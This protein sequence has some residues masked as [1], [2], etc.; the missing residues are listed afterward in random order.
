MKKGL[1]I[2]VGIFAFQACLYMFLTYR[3]STGASATKSTE[4]LLSVAYD[5]V[6]KVLV[7]GFDKTSVELVKK[8]GKW[9]V[10]ALYNVPVGSDKV[11]NVLK[12]LIDSK[13]SWALGNTKAAA[14][15]FE[16]TDDKFERKISFYVKDKV[17]TTLYLGN[18]PSY[19]KIYA[20]V[21]QEDKTYSVEFNAVDAPTLAKD[22]ADHDLYKLDK[23]K[24][25]QIKF[26]DFTLARDGSAFVVGGLKDDEM[27]NAT[28]VESFL[29]K[30]QNPNFEDVFA[31][32]SHDNAQKLLEYTVTSEDKV[33][34]HYTYFEMK[35]TAP[36]PVKSGEAEKATKSEF[37]ALKVSGLA[38]EF[39]IRKNL[40][41]DLVK[42]NRLSFVKKKEANKSESGIGKE[43]GQLNIPTKSPG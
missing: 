30:I 15:Q 34:H 2:L 28:Q 14:K 24:I 37:V 19:K 16:V 41:D 40:V 1:N 31:E 25:S 13:R 33:E 3:E 36:P 22:W 21:D 10:P 17:A 23:A 32:G 4:P 20:R 39:K 8:D 26:Q 27:T 6:D 11:D 5:N 18:S 7:E 43:A 29:S 35:E 42:F 38:Y 12:K 9:I